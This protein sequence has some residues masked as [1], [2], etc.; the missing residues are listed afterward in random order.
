MR[1]LVFG[2]QF[3]C[4]I[5]GYVDTHIYI[6]RRPAQN[7]NIHIVCIYVQYIS[8]TNES[9]KTNI[10]YNDNYISKNVL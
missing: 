10:C 1:L 7:H 5:M 2:G 9:M 3:G 6:H 8:T 4:I